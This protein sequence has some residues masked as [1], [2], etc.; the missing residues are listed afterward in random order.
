[1]DRTHLLTSLFG[2]L[3]YSAFSFGL[4][5]NC[6][7]SSACEYTGG[8]F[9][10]LVNTVCNEVPPGNIYAPNV[11]IASNC[12]GVGGLSAFTQNTHQIITGAQ[13]CVLLRKLQD[14]GCRECGSVPLGGSNNDVSKGELTVNYVSSCG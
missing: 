4:G 12:H 3:L 5:I 10:A 11:R 2:V 8:N 7:G 9:N 1:M 13:A 6:R 14:H